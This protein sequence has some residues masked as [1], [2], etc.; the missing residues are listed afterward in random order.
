MYPASLWRVIS[1][2]MMMIRARLSLLIAT[3]VKDLV[4][5]QG[6]QARR[7]TMFSSS[8]IVLQTSEKRISTN[9]FV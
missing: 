1:G 2:R 3:V 4:T 8:P 7:L 9:H 6:F 5:P